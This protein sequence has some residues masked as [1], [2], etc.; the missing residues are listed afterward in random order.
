[1]KHCYLLVVLNV[2]ISG[3]PNNCKN[4]KKQNFDFL[5]YRKSLCIELES[6]TVVNEKA[7]YLWHP[8]LLWKKSNWPKCLIRFFLKDAD[9]VQI[10]LGY[11]YYNN[12]ICKKLIIK[13]VKI[14]CLDS[15]DYYCLKPYNE[16]ILL[17]N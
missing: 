10:G 13:K 9:D 14:K 4:L 6:P 12:Q 11:A 7:V 2:A 8:E 15:S 17:I 5:Q 16:Y 3:S 1:M